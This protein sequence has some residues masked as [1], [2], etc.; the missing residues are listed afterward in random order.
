MIDERTEKILDDYCKKINLPETYKHPGFWCEKFVTKGRT[1]K[2]CELCGDTIPQGE[3]HYVETDQ[4][5]SF[6]MH[7]KCR[8]IALRLYETYNPEDNKGY[9]I[10]E[11][12]YTC[13]EVVEHI[14]KI[15]DLI[16][17]E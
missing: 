13:P 14:E 6:P 4:E 17:E 10:E 11:V 9:G 8:D 15:Q 12:F 3:S 1:D 2:Y 16:D 7:C 5:C